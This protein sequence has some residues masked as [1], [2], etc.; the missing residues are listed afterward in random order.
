MELIF[1][2]RGSGRTLKCFECARAN[3]AIIVSDYARQLK[4]KAKSLGFDDL[5]IVA[6]YEVY[7]A[8]NRNVLLHKWD[9]KL[10]EQFRFEE[11][12][13][14]IGISFNDPETKIV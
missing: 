6:P 13:K 2:G 7:D 10:E 9:E 12:A 5:E 11:G 3:N 14:V 1:G 4:V 8:R